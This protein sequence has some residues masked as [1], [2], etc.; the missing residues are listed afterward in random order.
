LEASKTVKT[1]V[2]LEMELQIGVPKTVRPE[3]LYGMPSK[4]LGWASDIEG[5][6]ILH[7]ATLMLRF[8][9]SWDRLLRERNA[10]KT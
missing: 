3:G 10:W 2:A 8:K 5:N 1:V 6:Q 4:R 9:E 7:L